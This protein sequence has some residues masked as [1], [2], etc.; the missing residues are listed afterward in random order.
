MLN[1]LTML[2]TRIRGLSM[3]AVASSMSLS[4]TGCGSA[5][6]HP[7]EPAAPVTV[8]VATLAVHSAPTMQDVVGT[9]RASDT[10]Q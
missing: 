8:R 4:L 5:E 1:M 7:A 6:E 3:L 9:T 2:N 10:G